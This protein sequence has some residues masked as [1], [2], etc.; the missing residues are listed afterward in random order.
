MG[1]NSFAD[2]RAV[3]QTSEFVTTRKL[4]EENAEWNAARI[5]ARQNGMERLA[6]TI[7]RID[8]LS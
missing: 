8:Q 4:A 5:S 1:N 7:W 2:K 3:Y 6:T